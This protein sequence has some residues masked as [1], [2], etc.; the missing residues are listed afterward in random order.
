MAA[1]RQQ[2]IRC[3]RKRVARL[4]RQQHP[5]ARYHHRRR[6]RTTDSR[7]G[8]AVAPNRL[9]RQFSAQRPNEKWVADFTYVDTSEGWLYL[10]L[11]LDVFSHKFVGWDMENHMDATLVE[12]ALR[13][14]LSRRQPALGELLHHSDR[15]SQYT[16]LTYQKL[17]AVHHITVSMSRTAEPHNNAAASARSRPNVPTMFFPHVNQARLSPNIFPGSKLHFFS[18]N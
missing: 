10:A 3:N 18:S 11:V 5:V 13:M 9:N 6:V 4:M 15:G 17:L 16:S 12:Q 7:H 14:A 1:L 8:F 2:G